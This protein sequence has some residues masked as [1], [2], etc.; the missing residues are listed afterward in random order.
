[1]F[2]KGFHRILPIYYYLKGAKVAEITVSHRRR[3]Y[4]VTKYG[5]LRTFDILFEVI[6]INFFENKSSFFVYL[7]CVI[8]ATL[9]LISFGLLFFKHV[10]NM[11]L[12]ISLLAFIQ[13]FYLFV[14]SAFLYIGR[15]FYHYQKQVKSSKELIDVK[16]FE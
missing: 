9:I 4:G 11:V 13:G 14:L 2:Y 16:I 15:S 10:F 6:K 1:M 7:T 3:V 12:V 8:G 5:F